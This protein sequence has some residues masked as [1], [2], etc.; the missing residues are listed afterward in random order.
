M[1]NAAGAGGGF[2]GDVMQHSY[3][4]MGGLNSP[5][6][7]HRNHLQI[8]SPQ[9]T[10]P[11]LMSPSLLLS[12][13]LSPEMQQQLSAR[14]MQNRMSRLIDSQIIPAP[15]VHRQSD[16]MNQM[17]PSQQM[18]MNAAMGNNF[19]DTQAL[20]M[21][22]DMM[23][24]KPAGNNQAD[25][26]QIQMLQN[27]LQAI[28]ATDQFEPRPIASR[29]SNEV[30]DR[31]RSSGPE[32]QYQQPPRVEI[33]PGQNPRRMPPP[34]LLKREGSLRMDKIFS[35]TSPGAGST[36]K[37]YDGNGSSAHLSAMSLSLGDMNDDGNLSSVF[38]SSLRISTS[39]EKEL[40][41]TKAKVKEERSS[42]N[43]E[44]EQLEM[45]VAT[46]GGRSSEAGNM[47]FATFGD[48]KMHES[49]GNMSFTRVFE[50]P[51]K[52]G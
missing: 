46:F 41:V 37:K 15:Q 5:V 38:D 52:L 44:G 45:S 12:S 32:S 26:A 21:G 25:F 28:Y 33:P 42:S 27:K 1:G 18:M 29:S 34:S 23:N 6:L 35:A 2:P 4:S 24:Q 22:G 17:D 16:G 39:S 43:W 36:K 48:P 3:M 7:N 51:D 30:P 50:D 8:A 40:P 11:Q 47:S 19:S 31:S 49:E 20:G 10:S 9:L 13:Q 14:Q